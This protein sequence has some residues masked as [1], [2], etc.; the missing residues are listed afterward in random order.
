MLNIF[1]LSNPIF[2]KKNKSASFREGAKKKRKNDGPSF[3]FL[4]RP[5]VRKEKILN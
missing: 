4:D 2:Y 3:I 1:Y 5:V